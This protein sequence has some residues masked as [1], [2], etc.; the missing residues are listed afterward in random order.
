MRRISIRS[1]IAF[2]VVS[3]VGLAA[4]KNAS[5]FWAVAVLLTDLVAIGV[6]VLGAAF[7][8]GPKQ[9]W[10]AGFALLSCGYLAFL[11]GL[12][13]DFTFH[14]QAVTNPVLQYA[15]DRIHPDAALQ[16]AKRKEARLSGATP[17]PVPI[18]PAFGEFQRMA[19]AV[20]APLCGLIGGMTAAWFYARRERDGAAAA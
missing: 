5:E 17:V 13:F 8:R 10:W 15:Y 9:A 4:L 20:L 7:S 18:A 11:M 19:H 1:L 16:A 14:S 6:A 2:V 12:W 3:A